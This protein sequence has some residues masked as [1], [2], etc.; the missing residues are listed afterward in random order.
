MVYNPEDFVLQP[1]R[2]NRKVR[3]VRKLTIRV[4]LDFAYFPYL[5]GVNH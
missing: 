3:V 5:R 2:A 4:R 1:N